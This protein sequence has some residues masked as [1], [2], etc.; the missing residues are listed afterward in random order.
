MTQEDLSASMQDCMLPTKHKSLETVF[1]PA[2]LEKPEVAETG[3]M[4]VV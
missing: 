2:P 4:H 1:S 3:A